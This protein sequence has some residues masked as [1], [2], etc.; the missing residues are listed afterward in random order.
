MTLSISNYKI[1]RFWTYYFF[2]RLFYLLFA[3]LVYARLTTL[4][5]TEWYLGLGLRPFSI[6]ILLYDSTGFMV[7]FGGIIGTFFRFNM[8]LS[9]LPSMLASFFTVKWVVEKLSLRKYINN[10]LLM[11]VLSFPNF[12]IWTTLWSKEFFGLIY[13]AIIAMLI[14]NFLNGI[15]KIKMIDILG[16]YLC[17]LFNSQYLPF[18]LQGLIYIYIARSKFLKNNPMGQLRLAIIFLCINI[19]FLY[20]IRDIINQYAVMMQS[21]FVHYAAQATRDNIFLEDYDFFRY[22]PWGMFVAFFGP[23]LTEMLENPLHLIA[24]VESIFKIALFF[25]LTKH[26]VFKGFFYFRIAPL[27]TVSYFIILMGILFIHYPFGVFNPGAAVRYR[28]RFIFL[29]MVLLL[30]LYSLRQSCYLKRKQYV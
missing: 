17:W 15:Y 25:Y 3:V 9:N 14:I 27:I 13:T 1:S 29:F 22:L 8:V 2:I 7:F 10:T 28:S 12:V 4:G 26:I 6:S 5:D 20:L 19:I 18:I 24:G 23:T 30:Y 21:F 16:L 11:V